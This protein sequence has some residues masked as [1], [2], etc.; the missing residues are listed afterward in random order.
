MAFPLSTISTKQLQSVGQCIWGWQLCGACDGNPRCNQS[1]CPWSRTEQLQA[2][3]DRYT[4]LTEAYVPEFSTAQPALSSHEDLLNIIRVIRDQPDLKRE[5][6]IERHFQAGTPGSPNPSMISDQNRSMNIAASILFLTNCGTSYE[7]ADFVE[8]GGTSITWQDHVTARNFVSEAYPTNIHPY[9]DQMSDKRKTEDII[10]T[11]IATKLVKAGFVIEPTNDLRSHLTLVYNKR[12]KV[13]R[14][15][16]GAA[17]LKEMLLASQATIDACMIPRALVLEV[18]DTLYHVLFPSDRASQALLSSLVRKQHF[19]K[20]LLQYD[21]ARYRRKDDP[22]IVYSY[23]GTRI[24]DIYDEVQDP[25]P[26]PGWESWFQKY[27][28]PRYMLMATMIG[29]FIAV[30]LGFLG[31]AVASFQTWVSYQQ[32]KHPVRGN[33]EQNS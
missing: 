3:W 18:L 19:D 12:K 7:C 32:W 28:S 27:S 5:Q 14:V 8:D 22:D 26:R 31:L 1:T 13:V 16:H 30:I 33:E 17:V 25:T 15:F 29:V 10:A 9:F 21:M 23:F 11:M 4:T 20:S 24:A 2:F 6:L